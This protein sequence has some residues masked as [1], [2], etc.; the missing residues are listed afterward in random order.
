MK[1]VADIKA[2]TRLSAAETIGLQHAA[3]LDTRTPSN[4]QR[5][6]IRLHLQ[7]VLDRLPPDVR[8][9]LVQEW[10]E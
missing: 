3:K 2:K 6:L 9:A 4:L 5:H 1:T 7:S 8:D 10:D